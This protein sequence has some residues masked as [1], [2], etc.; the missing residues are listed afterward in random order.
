MQWFGGLQ[1]RYKGRCS[2]CYCPATVTIVSWNS[3]NLSWQ[4]ADG[5]EWYIQCRSHVSSCTC[6]NPAPCCTDV[7]RICAEC[8]LPLSSTSCCDEVTKMNNSI[9]DCRVEGLSAVRRTILKLVYWAAALQLAV[10]AELRRERTLLERVGSNISRIWLE[11]SLFLV[12]FQGNA[13]LHLYPHFRP[14]LE[15]KGKSFALA[16]LARVGFLWQ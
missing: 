10:T 13:T 12:L 7:Q 3:E 1:M 6:C 11:F 16:S 4:L 14:L 8:M 5:K 15:F 2:Q 9:F